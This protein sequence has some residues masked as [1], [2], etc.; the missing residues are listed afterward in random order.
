M[1]TT[2]SSDAGVSDAASEVLR[3]VHEYQFLAAQ[4]ALDAARNE[5]LE[6]YE[7][8]REEVLE[9][10]LGLAA[11]SARR[12]EATGHATNATAWM[13]SG[14]QQVWIGVRE[15]RCGVALACRIEVTRARRDVILHRTPPPRSLPPRSPGRR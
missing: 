9:A 11:D 4:A 3:T 2:G 14:E 8:A 7:A 6:Q 5:V 15:S 12:L 1:T 10:F 13:V